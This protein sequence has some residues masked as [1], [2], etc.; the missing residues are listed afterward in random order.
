[1]CFA[2]QT[3]TSCAHACCRPF[4][5]RQVVCRAGRRPDTE[6]TVGKTYIRMWAARKSNNQL[7][8]SPTLVFNIGECGKLLGESEGE[9]HELMKRTVCAQPV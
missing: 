3:S 6:D 9:E 7:H 8:L 2:A 1:M 5:R 4:G